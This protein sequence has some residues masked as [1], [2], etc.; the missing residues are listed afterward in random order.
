MNK[1][2]IQFLV[3][4][5]CVFGIAGCM[6]S[7]TQT[8]TRSTTTAVVDRVSRHDVDRVFGQAAQSIQSI[9]EQSLDRNKNFNERFF[10]VRLRIKSDGTVANVFVVSSSLNDTEMEEHLLDLIKI[11][12]FSDGNFREWNHTHTLGFVGSQS[13]SVPTLSE[14]LAYR[15]PPN[16]RYPRKARRRGETGVVLVRVLVDK[17]GLVEHASIER[18]SDNQ[19]L[20][21]AA[22]EAVSNASFYPYQEKGVA[23]PV[24]FFIPIEFA[25]ND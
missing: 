10:V 1:I 23:L 7:K 2:K 18:S 17:T 21:Q 20:D 6:P 24:S 22:L 13:I 12:R 5:L 25:F 4:F 15:V 19:L 11:F 3:G 9:Y 16:V 8:I 14:G